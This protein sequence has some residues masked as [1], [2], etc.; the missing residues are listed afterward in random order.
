VVFYGCKYGG[1]CFFVGSVDVFFA[2]FFYRY[3]VAF[4][5]RF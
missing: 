5:Q 3:N 2:L 4:E 1:E